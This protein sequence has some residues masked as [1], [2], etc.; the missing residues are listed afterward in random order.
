MPPRNPLQIAIGNIRPGVSIFPPPRPM[1]LCPDP[2]YQPI[3]GQPMGSPGIP[4]AQLLNEPSGYQS[5]DAV[6]YGDN[7]SLFGGWVDGEPGTA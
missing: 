3:G 7:E 6:S 2:G 4:E 5:D 1:Q